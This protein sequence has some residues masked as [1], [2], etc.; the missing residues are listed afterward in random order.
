[1]P[2][3]RKPSGRPR[4]LDRAGALD[5]AIRL[6][7]EHGY[8]GT[9]LAD[10]TR[11]M[12]MS[13]PSVYEAF[14]D[15]EALFRQA[16]AHYQRRRTEEAAPLLDGDGSAVE[17]VVALILQSVE[18]AT[19]PGDPLGCLVSGA[20]GACSPRN[21]AILLVAAEARAAVVAQVE[22][23]LDRGVLAGEIDARIDRL[24]IARFVAAL[25]QGIS[26]QARDGIPRADLATVA[27]LGASA[28]RLALQSAA[29]P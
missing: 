16:L 25:L 10:L 19:R 24:G 8:E 4:T 28:V 15:K 5:A 23:R 11:A 7:W 14:G 17:A 3:P 1:M 27:N 26:V 6:F 29:A 9:S 12:G 20:P 18:Q 22:A 21:A 13:P 2:E